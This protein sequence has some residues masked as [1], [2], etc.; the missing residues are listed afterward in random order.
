MG[1]RRSMAEG[2]LFPESH[3]H[4]EHARPPREGKASGRS[5]NYTATPTS[6]RYASALS[7]N[8]NHSK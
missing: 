3:D 8:M 2:N 5:G 1:Q 4:V 7:G 6:S